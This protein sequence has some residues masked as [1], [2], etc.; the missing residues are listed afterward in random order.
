MSW[1][2][3]TDQIAITFPCLNFEPSKC[4]TL[5][6]LASCYNPVGLTVPILLVGKS[7]YQNC[8]EHGVSRDQLIADA[9]RKK[10]INLETSLPPSKT[11]PRTF[12]LH[13]KKVEAIDLHVFGDARITKIYQ[14][15]QV[16]QGLV[17]VNSLSSKKDLAIQRLELVAM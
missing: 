15:V 6:K 4:S 1:D 8:C 16:S 9:Y 7:M 12:Q 11:V 2:K 10:W 5:Q 17:T 14:P 3:A 13:Q